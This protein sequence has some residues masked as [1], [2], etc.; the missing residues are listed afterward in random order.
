MFGS[1]HRSRH[2]GRRSDDGWFTNENGWRCR[3]GSCEKLDLGLLM[4]R[5][6]MPYLGKSGTTALIPVEVDDPSFDTFAVDAHG[7]LY[8]SMVAVEKWALKEVA[9]VC[10]HEAGHMLRGHHKRMRRL[11]GSRPSQYEAH[12]ANIAADLEI[13]DDSLNN[14]WNGMELPEGAHYP[15]DHGFPEGLLL[16]EYWQLLLKKEREG[17]KGNKPGQGQPGQGGQ[18]GQPGQGPASGPVEGPWHVGPPDGAGS[19]VPGRNAGQMAVVVDQVAQDIADAVAKGTKGRGSVPA[20]WRGWANSV[21]TPPKIPWQ[22]VLA[23]LVRRAVEHQRGML[24]QSMRRISKKTR[25]G[26]YIRPGWVKPVVTAAVVVDTSKSMTDKDL[27]DVLSEVMG[28][29]KSTGTPA[30]MI[31][32]SAQA[33]RCGKVASAGSLKN[34]RVPGGGTDMGAGIEAAANMKPNADVIIVLTD[35]DTPWPSRAPK[36]PTIVCLTNELHKASVPKWVRA[37]VVIDK[38]KK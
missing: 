30:E 27:A 7:R 25:Q 10:V 12:V 38:K 32:C 36:A 28:I 13:N 2:S 15:K 5:V 4:V 6:K 11:Y 9:A 14:G 37:T 19:N 3:L 22:R 26:S 35:G 1:R 20:G 34:M 24:T 33:Q 18:P 23:G 17:Q 31:G 21:L 8:W 29:V 16:E